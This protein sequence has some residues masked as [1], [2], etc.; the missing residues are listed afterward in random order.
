M[1]FDLV[2]GIPSQ[3]L[4]SDYP[5][6]ESKRALASYRANLILDDNTKRPLSLS[7]VADL[8]A[9]V[10]AVTVGVETESTALMRLNK[11]FI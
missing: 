5:P 10:L 9:P 6:A 1:N 4:L 7:F 11:G 2:S 8:L 3:E